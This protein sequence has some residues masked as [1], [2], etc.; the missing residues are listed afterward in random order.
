MTD[1]SISYAQI[2]LEQVTTYCED[3]IANY[4]LNGQVPVTK[5]QVSNLR[6]F[7]TFT[8]N[9][10]NEYRN[11]GLPVNEAAHLQARTILGLAV[12]VGTFLTHLV[13]ANESGDDIP[14]RKMADLISDQ[15]R[16]PWCERTEKAV[17]NLYYHCPVC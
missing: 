14:A 13:E 9:Q 4:E 16:A 7:F 8:G 2:A 3:M 11:S 17:R 15:Y 1:P 5:T 10:I 12:N 6:A